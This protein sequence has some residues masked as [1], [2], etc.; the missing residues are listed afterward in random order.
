MKKVSWLFITVFAILTFLVGFGQTNSSK[1]PTTGKAEADI[2]TGTEK[3]LSLIETF[4]DVLE[5]EPNNRSKIK[6]LGKE[7]GQQW[8]VIEKSVEKKYPEEYDD[9]E[10]SL[11]PLLVLSQEESPY[12]T[13]LLEL[14]EQV[15]KKLD[16]LLD[17]ID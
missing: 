6:R 10:K 3:V 2:V 17:M 4:E 16:D 15:E 11:Y 9:I 5:D 14:S 8:Q 12:V 13:K 7:I 1:T